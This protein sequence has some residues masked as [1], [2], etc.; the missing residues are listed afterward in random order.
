[1]KREFSALT[2]LIDKAAIDLD[3]FSVAVHVGWHPHLIKAAGERFQ[4]SL[5][6]LYKSKD[7]SV[8]PIANSYSNIYTRILAD[9]E[10]REPKAYQA[11][12]LASP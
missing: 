8:K 7:P 3:K 12:L 5:A 10:D 2:N 1:M 4:S 9:M 11:M 6:K